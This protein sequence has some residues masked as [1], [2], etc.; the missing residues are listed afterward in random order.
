MSSLYFSKR[1]QK[2]RPKK[3]PAAP[4]KPRS[5]K[6]EEGAKKWAAENKVKNFSVVAIADGSKFKI[7][8]R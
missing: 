5:F 3:G 6:S 2:K 7:R 4:V 8:V 1:L